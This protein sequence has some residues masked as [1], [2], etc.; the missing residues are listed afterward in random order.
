VSALAVI[1]DAPDALA[2]ALVLHARE[3]GRA[4][5]RWS[6]DEAAARLCMHHADGEV[7]VAPRVALFLRLPLPSRQWLD[8][9]RQFHRAEVCSHVWAAAALTPAPVVNRPDAWGLAGRLSRS[10]AVL[11]RRAGLPDERAEIFCSHPPEL[12]ADAE[13][14]WLER[15]SDRGILAWSAT[16]RERGPYRGAH[17]A[18]DAE[19]VA[20]TVVDGEAHAAHAVPQ[21]SELLE[22]SC[23]VCAALGLSFATVFWRWHE[24]S[25]VAEL[26]GVG[27]PALV[28]VGSAW[29]AV[30]DALLRCL[31]R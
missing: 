28:T 5:E 30:A 27:Q 16:S 9:E 17:V 25:G 4:V 26:G 14:W 22:R 23:R 10:T 6:Y 7:D 18:P 3:A 15:Q 31:A 21:G 20:V 1:A 8:G 24:A 19:P 12:G 2:D 29:P 11:R 13:H